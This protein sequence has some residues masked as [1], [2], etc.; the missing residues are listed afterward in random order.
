MLNHKSVA[1]PAGTPVVL[2]DSI[3][4]LT[5]EDAGAI[6]VCASHGGASSG[7]YASRVPLSLVVFND[8]G[9]GKDGAG[10][11]SLRILE[12]AG[13]A[14]ATVS[15]NSARIG[16]VADQWEHGVIS[17]TNRLADGGGLPVGVP[18]QQAV[19]GW[20]NSG[21]ANQGGGA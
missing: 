5:D 15:H 6:V 14:A 20:S 16:D 11:A 21:R 8:A 9:V 17:Q 2:C 18:V 12:E 3:S 4:F 1:T 13:V 19:D 7:E 10:I